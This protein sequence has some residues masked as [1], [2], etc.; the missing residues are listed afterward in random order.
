MK[1]MSFEDSKKVLQNC[2]LYFT[3]MYTRYTEKYIRWEL[4]PPL[5]GIQGNHYDTI[6]LKARAKINLELDGRTQRE[7]GYH[8][9]RMVMQM[10]KLYDQIDINRTPDI[11][12]THTIY[13]SCRRMSAILPTKRQK[14]YDGAV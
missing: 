7:D 3:I 4:K 11:R 6:R 14:G 9:V 5:R 13:P 8:G 10:L 12:L 2:R 1:Q